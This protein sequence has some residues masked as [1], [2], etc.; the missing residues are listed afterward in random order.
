MGKN[1]RVGE[2]QEDFG[3]IL[4]SRTPPGHGPATFYAMRTSVRSS[5]TA[6]VDIEIAENSPDGLVI[7]RNPPFVPFQKIIRHDPRILLCRGCFK[8]SSPR[9]AF[10]PHIPSQCFHSLP[11]LRSPRVPNNM[12]SRVSS[13]QHVRLTVVIGECVGVSLCR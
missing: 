9:P 7:S 6:V 4:Q 3:N 2:K 1:V 12:E 13:F 5:T 8:S 11:P 10:Q